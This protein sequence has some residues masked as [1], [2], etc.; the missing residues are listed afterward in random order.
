MVDIIAMS[1]ICE[2]MP[3]HVRLVLVGDP[4]Q[5][6]PVG[7]GLVLHAVASVPAVPVVELKV[8]KRHGDEIRQAAAAI[9][10][11]KWPALTPNDRAAIAF[12]P[13]EVDETSIAETVLAL[14][15]QDPANT[16][17]LSSRRGGAGGTKGLNALCQSRLTSARMAIMTWNDEHECTEHTGIHLGD[18]VLCTRNLWDRGLQNGSLGTVV[19]TVDEPRP[20]ADDEGSD[21]GRALAWVEW[22]DGVRRPL[23]EEMLD[24]L[25]L[26]YAITVHKAQGS[27]WPRVIVA[28][29]GSRLLDR[30]LLYTAVTRARRQ[31]ILV[32][33]DAAAR[34]AVARPPRALNRQV[35]LDLTLQRLLLAPPENDAETVNSPAMRPELFT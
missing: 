19:Q 5:L 15:L 20:L 27:Q 26:G 12:V 21:A 13:C 30:T 25:E 23:L 8:V 7:P 18:T 28:V 24:D 31:V 32:G 10:D 4:N 1:R 33:D 9:R 29:T 34:D 2:A 3:P 6:M 22:D 35:A 11:G 14:Y 17:I 16:Q